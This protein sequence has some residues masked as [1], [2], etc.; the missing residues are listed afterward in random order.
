MRYT[1]LDALRGIAALAVVLFHFTFGIDNGWYT[2]SPDKFYFRYGNLGVHLF[3]FISGFVIFMTLEKTK[4]SVS[5]IVSRFSRLYPAYWAAIFTTVLLTTLLSVPFQQGIYSF[6]QVLVNLTMLQYW[7]KV[8]NVDGA[9]WTLAVELTFYFIMWII[10]VFK[11]LHYIE[12]ISLIWLTISLVFA[13]LDIPLAKYINA[14]LI[15]K[16]APLFISGILFYKI[17]T[18]QSNA[19]HHILVFLSFIVE[20]IVLYSTG[21]DF[22]VYTVITCYYAIFYLFVYG[23]MKFLNNKALLFLGSISYTL[24]LIHENIGMA[25]IYWFKKIADIQIIYL[26][27]TIA[28]VILIAS[29]ITIYIEKPAMKWI[30]ESY[31]KSELKKKLAVNSEL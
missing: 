26:P 10:Y 27:I 12:W 1:E 19:Y 25:I 23:L 28:I 20:T 9:Y 18:G 24:Y 11:K 21:A 16:Y 31:K 6:K 15:L 17:K 13:L 3:F 14:I 7:L 2:I 22:V 29:F 30:R 8:E 5:F 4:N